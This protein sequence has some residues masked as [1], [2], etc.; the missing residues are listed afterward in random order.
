[1]WDQLCQT[2]KKFKSTWV[3]KIKKLNIYVGRINQKAQTC[4]LVGCWSMILKM[5][6]QIQHWY[7]FGEW[8]FKMYEV[9]TLT[10]VVQPPTREKSPP[11]YLCDI[12]N[13]KAWKTICVLVI[14]LRFDWIYLFQFVTQSFVLRCYVLRTE[15]WSECCEDWKIQN[16]ESI[17]WKLDGLSDSRYL[18]LKCSL[19]MNG[20]GAVA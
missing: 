10:W 14:F 19:H 12:P 11:P 5:V 9:K 17:A 18:F 4:K 16:P 7:R 15:L 6:T 1:M 13:P 2:S 8:Y 3:E 20:I